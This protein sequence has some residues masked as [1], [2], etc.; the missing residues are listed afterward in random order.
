[1]DNVVS[2]FSEDQT[3][4]LTGVRK[5]QLRYWDKTRFFSPSFCNDSYR[6]G[7]GRIY[8]F[9]D[10]VSL[11]V[12]GIL[13]NKHDVSVQHL[14]EVKQNL[15][16]GERS[17]W[18][19]VKLY[20]V[21]KRV[22]WVEPESGLPQDVASK[23]YALQ[24]ID[25]D[26]VVNAIR[27]DMKEIIKRDSNKVGKIERVRSLNKSS[28]VIAGTRITVDAILRYHSAGYS[29]DQILAE[30]PDLKKAD[31]KSALTFDRAA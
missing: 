2:A 19:G 15:G 23:Q 22:H 7:F 30:Y 10:L 24:P 11:K 28:P 26:S 1:M 12:L 31:V 16:K 21:N 4:R 17:T 8:S 20:A 14:R 13:R 6:D 5:G 18:S 25:L 3:A 29:V 27:G 9:R